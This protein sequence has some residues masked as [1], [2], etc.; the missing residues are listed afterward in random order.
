[1][2]VL[3]DGLVGGKCSKLSDGTS[4]KDARIGLPTI[5]R[6]SSLLSP[7]EERVAMLMC[8]DVKDVSVSV[9]IS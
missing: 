4:E 2:G 6:D 3:A 7:M 9:S 1:M 5:C 8:D